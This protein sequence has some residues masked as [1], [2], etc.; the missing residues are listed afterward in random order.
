[1]TTEAGVYQG[2]FEKNGRKKHGK[3]LMI[4]TNGEKYDG[5]W[6]NDKKHGKG[7]MIYKNGDKYEGDWANDKREGKGCLTF[8]ATKAQANG[9][10]ENDF[11][12][13]D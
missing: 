1:M 13:D 10:W 7:Q 3:G 6:A 5:F 4:Y 12:L 2:E 9:R 8:A 11:F